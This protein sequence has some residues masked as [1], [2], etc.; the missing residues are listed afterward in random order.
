MAQNQQASFNSAHKMDF[1][2]TCQTNTASYKPE[3][4]QYHLQLS[5]LLYK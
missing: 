5:N 3:D 2:F 1:R 4:K